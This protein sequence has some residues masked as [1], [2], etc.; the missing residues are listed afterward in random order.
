MSDLKLEHCQRISRACESAIRHASLLLSASMQEFVNEI[1][2]L[3]PDRADSCMQKIKGKVGATPE[4]RRLL[5][6]L[7]IL[8]IRLWKDDIW[9]SRRHYEEV[10]FGCLE[11]ADGLDRANRTGLGGL[12]L[13]EQTYQR[14]FVL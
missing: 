13:L 9:L 10:L 11:A 3:G 14:D 2:T 1:L 6:A 7:R 4:G 8:V 12:Y 5:E